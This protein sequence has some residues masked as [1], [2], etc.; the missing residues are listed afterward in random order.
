[1][2]I[3]NN[4]QVSNLYQRYSNTTSISADTSMSKSNKTNTD[5]VTISDTALNA[6]NKLEEI[7]NKYDPSNMS[8]SELTNM[9]SELQLSGL[10]ASEEGLAMRAPPSISFDPDKKYD[11]V[12]LAQK[13]VAFDQS[14]GTAQGNDARLRASVLNVLETIQNLSANNKE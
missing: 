14:I 1:M 11:A 7:A 10:I 5:S 4:S 6:A 9:S 8:Y 12:A 2:E 3:N 13:S